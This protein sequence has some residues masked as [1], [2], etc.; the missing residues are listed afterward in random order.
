[1]PIMHPNHDT[2]FW[3]IDSNFLGFLCEHNNNLELSS[4]TSMYINHSKESSVAWSQGER[5]TS[6]IEVLAFKNM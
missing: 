2:I 4:R 3:P 1:M 5:D 6:L